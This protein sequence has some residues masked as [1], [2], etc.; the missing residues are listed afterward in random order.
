MGFVG[1][2]GV[3]VPAGALVGHFDAGE[4]VE[5]ADDDDAMR[6]Q[7]GKEGNGVVNGGLG[8]EAGGVGQN[9]GGVDTKA[10]GE[11]A[12]GFGF[13]NRAVAGAAGE[14]KFFDEAIVI[15]LAGGFDA[16]SEDV[17][18][19]A[20]GIDVRAEDDGDVGRAAVVGFAEADHLGQRKADEA[21]SKGGEERERQTADRAESGGMQIDIKNQAERGEKNEGQGNGK[22]RSEMALKQGGIK[23]ERVPQR[24]GSQ[25]ADNDGDER[26]LPRRIWRAKGEV[27]ESERRD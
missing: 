7:P 6:M 1:G 27:E 19:A 9:I 13:V 2:D 12:H 11:A 18:R 17:G 5:M 4:M 20:I 23:F 14:D 3:H 15:E 25:E 21:G 10:D 8:V 24:A 26:A 22:E 16:V